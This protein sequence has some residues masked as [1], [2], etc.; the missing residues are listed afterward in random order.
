M[1]VVINVCFGGFSLSNAGIMRYAE[2]K[3]I[4]L[5]PSKGVASTTNYYLCPEEAFRTMTNKEQNNM[6]FST[7][8]FERD[9]PV[10][11]QV[12]EEL[13]MEANGTYASLKIVEIPD[14]IDWDIDEYDGNESIAEKHRS[15]S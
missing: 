3:G 8:H 10:L 4:K 2:L 5:Y 14:G 13:G 1:K 12:V 7:H 11:I 9:D 6:Y 15:W